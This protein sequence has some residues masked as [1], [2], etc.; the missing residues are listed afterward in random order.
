MGNL[1]THASCF[2]TNNP[3]KKC[4]QI[5]NSFYR[6]LGF[7]M[8]CSL[9]QKLRHARTKPRYWLPPDC[10]CAGSRRYYR[11]GVTIRISAH[12]HTSHITNTLKNTSHYHH[13]THYNKHDTP[14]DTSNPSSLSFTRDNFWTGLQRTPARDR[15]T[16]QEIRN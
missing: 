15:D 12:L 13:I 7:F 16:K 3:R 9:L 10:S 14:Q 5:L 4:P 1:A 11:R 6:M 2:N 8:R